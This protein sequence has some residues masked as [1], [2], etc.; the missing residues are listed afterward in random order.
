MEGR[1]VRRSSYSATLLVEASQSF[2]DHLVDLNRPQALRVAVPLDFAAE[3]GLIAEL[4]HFRRVEREA[5]LG[6][7][8]HGH[9]A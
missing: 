3:I 4:A 2:G 7:T 1:V 9:R 5:T 6:A 8:P